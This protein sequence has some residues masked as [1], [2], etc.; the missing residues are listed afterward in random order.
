[1]IEQYILSTTNTLDTILN[2]TPESRRHKIGNTYP[3][4]DLKAAATLLDILLDDR[5]ADPS[6][7]MAEH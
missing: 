3:L 4:A 5:A 1:M 6:V 2:K 7:S